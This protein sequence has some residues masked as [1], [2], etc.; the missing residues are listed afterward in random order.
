MHKRVSSSQNLSMCSS[1]DSHHGGSGVSG[2]SRSSL[3]RN[4]RR[5]G[6]GVEHNSQKVMSGAGS[7]RGDKQN[8]AEA[9]FLRISS[10]AEQR[11]KMSSAR[12]RSATQMT[13]APSVPTVL[14]KSMA[15]AD[16]ATL[17]EKEEEYKTRK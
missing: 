17:Q 6:G 5:C 12:R 7:S 4:S 9:S 14:S 16:T 1:T 3:S 13:S 8:A 15:N 2:R 11:A 10:F